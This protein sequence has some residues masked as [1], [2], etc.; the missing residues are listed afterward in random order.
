MRV[1]IGDIVTGSFAPGAMLPGEKDLALQFGVSRGV[2]REAV[3]G[4]EERG[5][6]AVKH[7]RGATVNADEQW[8]VLDPEVLTLLLRTDRSPDVLWQY[9]ECRRILEIEATGLAAA[10]AGAADLGDLADALARMT[11]SAERARANPAAE[12]LYHEADV[13]FH[14]AVIAATG[15]RALGRM[16]EPIHRGLAAARRPLARPELRIERSIPEHRRILAAIAER[17]DAGAREA[18]RDHLLTIEQYLR[19]YADDVAAGRVRGGGADVAAGRVR[20]GGADEAAGRVRGGGADEAAGRV[21]GGGVDGLA[22][23]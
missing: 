22:G 21:G 20:G 13:A 4:L 19:E 16:T 5:L 15:N 23:R 14:R 18:M 9:L 7:G 8:D 17:D 6:V 3:R 10:R 2:A 1:V 11:A 12:D